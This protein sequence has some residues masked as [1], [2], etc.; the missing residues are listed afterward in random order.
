MEKPK[1]VG[2]AE[3]DLTLT[4]KEHIKLINQTIEGEML[5]NL[6]KL[7]RKQT[8]AGREITGFKIEVEIKED[9]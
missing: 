9:N 1:C 7:V 2:Y 5:K 8:R 6:T 4:D 3:V